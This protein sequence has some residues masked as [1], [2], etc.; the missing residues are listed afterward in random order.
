MKKINFSFKHN[1]KIGIFGLSAIFFLYLLY[2]SLPSLY[3]TGRVQKALYKGLLKETG[4]ILSLSSNITYRILPSP[5]FY[6]QDTKMFYDETD[7]SSEVGEIKNLR[8][9]I[10]QKNLFNNKKFVF[11]KV[12]MSN[13]NFFVKRQNIDIIKNLFRNPFSEKKVLIKKSKLFFNDQN[14]NTIFIY[15]INDTSFYKNLKDNNKIFKTNGSIFKIPIKFEWIKNLDDKSTS[16]TF[17]ANKIDIDFSN[18]GRILDGKYIFENNLNILSNNFKTEYKIEKDTIKIY[19]KK[20]FIK[21][22]PVSFEGLVELNPFNFILNMTAKDI[23]LE[24]FFKNTIF[25]NE[26]LLSNI[27]LNDNLNGRIKIQTDKIYNSKIFN[28]AEFNITF[29]EGSF[30]FNN[31]YIYNEEFSNLYLTDTK[32]VNEKQK[33]F[34]LG[35][36]ELDIYNFNQFFR[37]FPIKKSKKEKR[38]FKKIKFNFS[39]NLSNSQFSIDK[40]SFLNKKNKV[41]QSENVDNV[42]EDNYKTYFS[43]SNSILFKNFMKKIL[44]A[45]L[46]EG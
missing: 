45:Y 20:S 9:F 14:N 42:V 13:A 18:K 37:I 36:L 19:S 2:L 25:L 28:N 46:D 43:L 40:I 12:T 17:K 6:I 44:I 16:S 35:S 27:L 23:D 5:H 30:N 22:T 10:S 29:E 8:V 26:L 34:L 39:F 31:S 41:V 21:N 4:L 33:I 7:V 1:L 11:K 3:D 15:S 32:F 24:Y 38:D